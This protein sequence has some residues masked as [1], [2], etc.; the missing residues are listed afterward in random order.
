MYKVLCRSLLALIYSLIYSGSVLDLLCGTDAI[1][2]CICYY[3]ICFT[4]KSERSW[5]HVIEVGDFNHRHTIN[6][7][8]PYLLYRTQHSHL[9]QIKSLFS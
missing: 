7:Q 4:G 6:L 9:K 2:G 3:L 5:C 1:I 8:L